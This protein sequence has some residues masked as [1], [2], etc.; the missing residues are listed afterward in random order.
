M[1]RQVTQTQELEVPLDPDWAATYMAA[2]D[3][4]KEHFGMTIEHLERGHAIISMPV[5]KEM[6]NGFEI[7]HGGVVFT[8]A[9]TAFAY[10]CNETKD[11]TVASG[12]DVSFLRP[13]FLGDTLTAE[14]RRVSRAGR[15]GLYDVT[16]TDQNGQ[17]VA[18]FRGRSFTTNRP[19]VPESDI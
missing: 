4:A 11:Q 9:D 7:T 1:E 13:T 5:R 14:G 3:N 12:A 18:Q 17:V 19:A 16:V 15:N 6:T 8:L 2:S 10:A